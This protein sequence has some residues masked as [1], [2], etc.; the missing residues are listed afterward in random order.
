MEEKFQ[1]IEEQHVQGVN[2]LKPRNDSH[3]LYPPPFTLT[4]LHPFIPSSSLIYLSLLVFLRLAVVS[5][6]RGY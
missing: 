1:K 5:A 2:M 4:P 3:R 6:L